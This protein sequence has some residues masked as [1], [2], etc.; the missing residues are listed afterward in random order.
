MKIRKRNLFQSIYIYHIRIYF[1]ILWVK[2]NFGCF[3]DVNF[4]VFHLLLVQI[5]L[6]IFFTDLDATVSGFEVKWWFQV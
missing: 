3:Y 6:F 1:H 5:L 4:M 2:F